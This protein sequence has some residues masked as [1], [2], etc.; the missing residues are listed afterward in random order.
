MRVYCTDHKSGRGSGS[1]N[2]TQ[3]DVFWE[4]KPGEFKIT[5][6]MGGPCGALLNRETLG[7][8]YIVPQKWQRREQGVWNAC[9]HQLGLHNVC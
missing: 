3:N 1:W 9:L 2:L 7:Y 6:R 4:V 5:Q 8:M